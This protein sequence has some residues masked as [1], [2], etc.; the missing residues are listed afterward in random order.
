MKNEIE[1]KLESMKCL[2]QSIDKNQETI[3]RE[4]AAKIKQSVYTFVHKI[5]Q[6][7]YESYGAQPVDAREFEARLA[8]KAN[9]DEML[10]LQSNKAEAVVQNQLIHNLSFV[11]ENIMQL[12]LAMVDYLRNYSNFARIGKKELSVANEF[13]SQLIAIHKLIKQ[14]FEQ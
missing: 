3:R 6:E 13:S 1:S 9:E 11:K 10:K 8:L 7:L 4:A 2:I 14:H 12:I 5:K